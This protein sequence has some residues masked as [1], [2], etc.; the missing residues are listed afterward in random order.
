MT[1]DP[2]E[3]QKGHDRAAKMVADG[4]YFPGSANGEIVGYKKRILELEDRVRR[5]E[6]RNSELE[7]RLRG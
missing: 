6:I 1:Y 3:I 4:E 5:L 7:L 2:R